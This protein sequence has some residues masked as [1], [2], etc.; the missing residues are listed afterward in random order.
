MKRQYWLIVLMILMVA[1][2]A[3]CGSE[4]TPELTTTPVPTVHPG[5]SIVASRCIA[6]HTLDQFANTT[7][8]ERGWR[9][10]VDRMVLLGAQLT[11]EQVELVV[12]YM[13][14]TYPY[15]EE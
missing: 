2:L 4:P 5:K 1:L 6:C 13:V 12:D 10:V 9:L 14:Q 15:P 7:F 8:N 11:D 3:A